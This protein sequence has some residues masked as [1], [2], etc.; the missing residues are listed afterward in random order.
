VA[1]DVWGVNS[2]TTLP[3]FERLLRDFGLR[4]E[5]V[6]KGPDEA[7][8]VMPSGVRILFSGGRLIGIYLSRRDRESNRAPALT[9]EREPSIA[10]M[11]S[12][13]EEARRAFAHGFISAGLVLAWGALEASMRRLAVHEGLKG[14]IGTQPTLLMRELTAS[15]R[16]APN[17]LEFLELARQ[18]RTS[19]VH[20]A[21]PA[22]VPPHVVTGLIDVTERLIQSLPE[23]NGQ[24]QPR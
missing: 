4:A 6:V 14:K 22:S 2:E 20:G 9:D 21:G 12:T 1:A 16:L 7:Y 19:I 11:R 13:L 8:L 23:Q 15:Q 3:E 24:P 5:R 10:E 17:D 18:L